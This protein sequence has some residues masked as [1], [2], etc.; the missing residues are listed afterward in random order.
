[1]LAL[2]VTDALRAREP[3]ALIDAVPGVTETEIA[4][5]FTVTDAA[6]LLAGSATLTARTLTTVA[7]GTEA[8]AT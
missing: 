3:P 7:A 4:A 6:A 8:G 1:M 2:P 5:G